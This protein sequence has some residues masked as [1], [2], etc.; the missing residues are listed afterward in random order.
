MQAGVN[1]LFSHQF[2]RVDLS[3]VFEDGLRAGDLPRLHALRP[4]VLLERLVRSPDEE[5]R[6]GD[7]KG[8]DPSDR[9]HHFGSLM[10]GLRS[11]VGSAQDG[12]QPVDGNHDD[13]IRGDLQS[14]RFLVCRPRAAFGLTAIRRVSN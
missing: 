12:E 14:F 11:M 8:G 9:Q 7:Q 5:L 2:V 4:L 10:C 6:G 13:H 3:V 1:G